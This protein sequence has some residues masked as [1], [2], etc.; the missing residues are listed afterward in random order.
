MKPPRHYQ[1]H[2]VASTTDATYR[3]K[4]PASFQLQQCQAKY[5]DGEHCAQHDRDHG[6]NHGLW[7]GQRRHI[8]PFRCKPWV[9]TDSYPA[10]GDLLHLHVVRKVVGRQSSDRRWYL[11]NAR[12]SNILWPRRFVLLKVCAPVR[13]R[14]H[15]PATATK[16]RA[17][18]L[19]LS[20]PIRVPS[21][22]VAASKTQA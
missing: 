20:C 15:V 12:M 4:R 6:Y 1:W 14:Q 8:K 5:E 21:S 11:L 10:H 16:P 18:K 2:Q 7:H 17:R 19:H 22:A 3:R 13:P 9:Q